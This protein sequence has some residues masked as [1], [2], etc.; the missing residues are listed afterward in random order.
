MTLATIGTSSTGSTI[1]GNG[2]FS[3]ASPATPAE[4]VRRATAM[5]PALRA[6][7]AEVD[8]LA[9][10]PET[11]IR[12]LDEARIFD[13]MVPRTHGGLQTSV[14][15][16][17]EV[18]TEIGRGDGSAA[19]AC[20]L[21]NICNWMV[22][23]LY[24]QHVTD[25]IFA[26]GGKIRTSGVLSPRVA[27]VRREQ[28]GYLIEEGLWGF[29]SGVYHAQWDLLG[30]PL[31]DETGVAADQGLALIPTEQVTLL[32]DWD[33]IGLRGSGSTSVSVKNV[34]VPDERIAALS[35]AIEGQYAS[36]HLG[37]EALY[38]TAFVP[39]LAI[40][41]V[42]PAMGIARAALELFL[43]KLPG[44]P[45]QYTWYEKQAEAA[46]THLQVGEA[47]AKI[48]AAQ[49]VIARCVDELDASAARG[50]YMDVETRA[51]IRRDTGY[52]GKLI[53]EAVDILATASGGSLAGSRNPFNRIWRDARIANLHG[54]VCPTTNLELF[55]RILCGQVPNTPLV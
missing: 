39:F 43:Q 47:S 12:E 49:L 44:R 45:I 4:L 41:L 16:Y 53:W 21:I 23:A 46:V 7:T 11:T 37:G 3:P 24:P 33:T 14:R 54:I 42:F 50:E 2:T 52:A 27:K 29:N 8:T 15:T 30:I 13:L 25:E 36:A 55:G 18:V 6:R 20:A 1:D 48:D 40:I 31:V 32:H 19:W 35:A 34:F 9:R 28:G 22:A 51:R 17:M 5:V 10:L 26:A 38:R